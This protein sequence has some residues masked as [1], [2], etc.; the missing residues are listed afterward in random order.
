MYGNLV[1]RVFLL[2]IAVT[3]LVYTG[4]AGYKVL[5]HLRYGQGVSAVVDRLVVKKHGDSQYSLYA[6][7]RYSVDGAEYSGE[8]L[9]TDTRFR[10]TWAV[11]HAKAEFEKSI[12]QKP[13]TVWVYAGVPSQSV[14]QRSFPL[15]EC[16]SAGLL[17]AL[18]G[19]FLWLGYYVARRD[20]LIG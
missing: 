3:T 13:L 6:F 1:Y 8:G 10:N 18:V 4:I 19:Y 12:Q 7:Y 20:G 2:L 15:K 17:I 14:V 9:I 11:Q 16:I 5:K